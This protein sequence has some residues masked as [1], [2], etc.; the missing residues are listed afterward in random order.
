MFIVA[1]IFQDSNGYLWMATKSG[2]IYIY[3]SDFNLQTVFHNIIIDDKIL[4]GY[5]T[6]SI[7]EDNQG[8]IW[9]GSKGGGILVSKSSIK[10]IRDGNYSKI[11]FFQYQH[12]ENDSNS[13][14][15]NSVYS[16]I[17]DQ[18]NQIWIS[19]YG[20]G[21]NKV[22]KEMEINLFVTV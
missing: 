21:I 18:D 2:E 7:L 8:Y 3:N 16:I 20:G 17:Q 1:S 9:L 6:Y 22:F 13:L 15:S 4:P 5:N 10:E 11:R 14:S 12:K 19:T